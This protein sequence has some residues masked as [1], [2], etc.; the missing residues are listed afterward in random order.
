M[1]QRRHHYEH[2]FESYLRDRRVPYVAVDEARKALIPE[3]ESMRVAG[4]T[5]AEPKGEAREAALK[6]FDFV[7]Y[8]QGTNFLIE[9]K[10]RRIGR[11]T[12]SMPPVFPRREG[13]GSVGRGMGTG[14]LE[15]WV[16]LDDIESLTAWGH[17]FG[18]EFTAAF[19]FV[20]WCDE[21]PP[22]ALF[23]EI[24]EHRGK[25]YA[26]RAITLADYVTAMKVR[27]LRW[28]TVHMPTAAFNRLSHSF[29]APLARPRTAGSAQERSL[30]EAQSLTAVMDPPPGPPL[31]DPW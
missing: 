17:L 3:G 9:V 7:I 19:V 10:G 27:S 23:E 5:Q 25:W 11:R 8:G 16:T 24:F 22:D 28:R 4:H 20:Y 1:A 14:R 29:S 2:A 15:S 31:L 6:S 21:Q 18:P 12:L 30:V 13:L 26:L